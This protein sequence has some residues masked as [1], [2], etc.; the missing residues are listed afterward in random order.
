M[1]PNFHLKRTVTNICGSSG[2]FPCT[3]NV[4]TG[5][6]SSN[7]QTTI[8]FGAGRGTFNSINKTLYLETV[9]SYTNITKDLS[10]IAYISFN[11]QPSSENNFASCIIN[12]PSGS[13]TL[14][15]RNIVDCNLS[16]NILNAS[17]IYIGV[18]SIIQNQSIIVQ[19][20]SILLPN[21]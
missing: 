19:S 7:S 3:Y 15:Y 2:N 4:L 18:P 20:G 16:N 6:D 14:V 11:S 8:I 1:N 10:F 9:I 21:F 5:S 13:G 12:L 17:Q